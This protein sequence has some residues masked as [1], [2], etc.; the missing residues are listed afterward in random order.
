MNIEEVLKQAKVFEELGASFEDSVI[1][2][3]AML[4]V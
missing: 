2:A 4:E 1:L 3:L